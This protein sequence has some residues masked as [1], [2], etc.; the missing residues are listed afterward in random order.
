MD[1]GL[2]YIRRE[3]ASNEL[4]VLELRRHHG[5]DAFYLRL[6]FRHSN[7]D[8]SLTSRTLIQLSTDLQ[9]QSECSEY[10]RG[11]RRRAEQRSPNH[12][13]CASGHAIDVEF[14]WPIEAIPRKAAGYIHAR[15]T[16]LKT[17]NLARCSLTI[18][19]WDQLRQAPFEITMRLTNRMRG[20]IDSG[21]ILFI[22]VDRLPSEV[23]VITLEAPPATGSELV[24]VKEFLKSKVY[25][26]GF[27]Q[28]GKDAVVWI[29]DPWDAAYLGVDGQSLAQAAEILEAEEFVELAGGMA[30]ASRKLLLQS[31]QFETGGT[32]SPSTTE[33]AWDLF[34]SHASEDK[35]GF[36]R[37]L[38]EALQAQGIRVWYDELTL[39]LGDSLRRRIDEGLVNSRYGIVVLSP[40]FFDKDW[41]QRELDGLVGLEV[42]GRKVILP[43]WHGVTKTDVAKFSPTLADRFA[44]SSAEG[45]DVVVERVLAALAETR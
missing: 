36:V 26:L 7:V 28:G 9:L 3:A 12:F 14:D 22:P 25:W 35:D 41:P 11:V 32:R 40:A 23:D 45:I 24:R 34:I 2:K 39:T 8:L 42:N 30:R 20:L 38:V 21:E 16:D 1:E 44:V 15:A 17:G 27:K 29:D 37:P 19:Y 33:R 43:L 6:G 4:Q 31:E 10:L 18:T 5:K 13:M